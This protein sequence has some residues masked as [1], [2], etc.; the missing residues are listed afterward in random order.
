MKYGL[1]ETPIVAFYDGTEQITAAE[2]YT[3]KNI[4]HVTQD[5]TIQPTDIT[6]TMIRVDNT[7][8]TGPSVVVNLPP[9]YE[10]DCPV[11]T[12]IQIAS[13]GPGPVYVTAWYGAQA[14]PFSVTITTM[15]D[16][17]M[18]V[19]IAPSTWAIDLPVSA[20]VLPSTEFT[21]PV[22]SWINGATS[23]IYLDVTTYKKFR[24]TLDGNAYLPMPSTLKDG[25]E[26]TI[27]LTKWSDF[28]DLMFDS[29]W[30]FPVDH[31]FT[32]NGGNYTT[33]ITGVY[34]AGEDMIYCDWNYYSP[35]GY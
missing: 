32:L 29:R 9:D 12:H 11:G 6:N 15:F 18:V 19:K 4:V 30:R 31:M 34:N 14:Y 35:P 10:L 27:V 33:K 7:N 28:Y 22:I 25:D 23:D 13:V 21:T 20:P 2:T 24:I 5:Y 1:I 8:T 3:L 16:R 26:I 17:V